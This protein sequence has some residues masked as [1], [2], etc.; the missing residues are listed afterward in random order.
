MAKLSVQLVGG[1]LTYI[2]H[3][4]TLNKTEVDKT[5]AKIYT[6]CCVLETVLCFYKTI[7]TPRGRSPDA[8]PLVIENGFEFRTMMQNNSLVNIKALIKGGSFTELNFEKRTL[9]RALFI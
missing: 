5:E 8:G 7:V 3:I 9:N 2:K 1:G 6:A 4:E